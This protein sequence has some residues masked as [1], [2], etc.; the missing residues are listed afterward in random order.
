MQ[1]EKLCKVQIYAKCIGRMQV[2]LCAATPLT[3]RVAG[4]TGALSFLELTRVDIDVHLNIVWD[5]D[6]SE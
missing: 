3:L 6:I 5:T 1:S 4:A 2:V